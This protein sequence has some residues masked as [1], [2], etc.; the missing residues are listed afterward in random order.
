MRSLIFSCNLSASL[1]SCLCLDWAS[2]VCLCN[3]VN[4]APRRFCVQGGDGVNMRGWGEHEGMGW[5]ECSYFF[6]F[7]ISSQL[8]PAFFVL[9][10]L[11]IKYKISIELNDSNEV[12]PSSSF[13][14]SPPLLQPTRLE[15]CLSA[16]V[17]ILAFLHS[18]VGAHLPACT[19]ALHGSGSKKTS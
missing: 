16:P 11:Y 14:Y 5:G 19:H 9:F 1:A 17:L 12:S 15:H 8:L 6:H 18:V 2:L 4:W 13:L 3:R 7:N 10:N